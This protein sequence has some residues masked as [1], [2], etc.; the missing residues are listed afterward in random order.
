M[1][2]NSLIKLIPFLPDFFGLPFPKPKKQICL[3]VEFRFLPTQSLIVIFL[4]PPSK[5]GSQSQHFQE[6]TF[7]ISFLSLNFWVCSLFAV[8]FSSSTQ[9]GGTSLHSQDY[10]PLYCWVCSTTPPLHWWFFCSVMIRVYLMP[11]TLLYQGR[12]PITTSLTAAAEMVDEI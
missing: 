1:Y 11:I 10:F 4:L 12:R 9:E 6:L 5:F 3:H 7:N 2:Q 8:I